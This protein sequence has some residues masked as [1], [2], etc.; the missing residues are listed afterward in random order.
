MPKF[1]LLSGLLLLLSACGPQEAPPGTVKHESGGVSSS[2]STLHI[3]QRNEPGELDPGTASIPDEFFIIRAL[4]E[5]L[6]TPNPD[7]GTPLPALAQSWRISEDQLN[8]T[9]FLRKA[10]WSDGSPVTSRD[11]LHSYQRVLNPTTASPK[12]ALF[13][14]V[15]GAE[16][17]LKGA[18]RDFN[19]V[20]FSTPDDLTL[21][22]R[23]Q[24][25]SSRFLH[26]VS[27]G[28][29]I[30]V[31]PATVEK[32][33][34][35]WTRPGNHVGN[36]AYVLDEWR[37]G[38]RIVLR[39]NPLYWDS[40]KVKIPVITLDPFDTAEAEERAFR[41]GAL[42]I[43]MS[44]PAT[45][46]PHYRDQPSPVLRQAVLEETRYLSFNLRRA[47]LDN[48]LV[49]QALSLALDRG[50]I[51]ERVLLGGQSPAY[52]F[53]HPRLAGA[54]QSLQLKEDPIEAARLLAQAG[55]P[56][57][58]GFPN[59]ELSSWASLPVLEALQAMWRERLGIHVSISMRDAKMHIVSMKE[60]HYDIAMMVAIPDVDDPL[61]LL[62]EYRTGMPGNYPGWSDA[63]FNTMLDHISRAA[64]EPERQSWILTAERRL[65]SQLPVT[66]IYFNTRN[67]LVR[68][69][70]RNW[71]EDGLWNRYYKLAQLGPEVS[72]VAE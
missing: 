58:A 56:G 7:G 48:P 17:Y 28:P 39:K 9:F 21:E 24:Q 61:N 40:A 49:R 27:T 15:F 66:P 6:V 14:L 18:L 33:G 43:T 68:P 34:R 11:F 59:L 47:P 45:K 65:L 4:G 57:G 37:P 10:S 23:L 53:L 5:G 62:G 30:P 19:K 1:A 70:V 12:A 3:S 60:G 2:A 25:P 69:R 22:I 13:L 55:Y 67:Y 42:D 64:E 51:C 50:R 8:Y 16:A 29:W 71:R 26:Y 46:I 20:G 32:H 72:A 31:H 41:A 52:R 38:G 36:G 35:A 63:G 44:V 54:E